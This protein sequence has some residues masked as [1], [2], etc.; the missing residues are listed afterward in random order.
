MFDHFLIFFFITSFLMIFIAK[1]FNLLVDFKL[2]KHKRFSTKSKSYFIG[3]TLLLFFFIYYFIF[4]EKNYLLIS[5][6]ISIFTIGL[7]SDLKILNSVKLR[8]LLQIFISIFFIYYL[9][10]KINFTRVDFFDEILQNYIVINIL[11]TTFC[12]LIVINGGNF[13]DGLNGLILKYNLII[14]LILY[15]SFSSEFFILDKQ[16]ASYL[17]IILSIILFLN[18]FGYLYM[19]DSGAYLLSLF[20]GLYLINFSSQNFALSPYFIILL[21]W[22]PCFELLFSM[23]R[24]IRKKLKTYKPDNFHLH[25]FIYKLI[26]KKLSIKNDLLSHFITSFLINIYNLII[27][28]ISVQFIYDSE[29]LILILS[30]NITLYLLIYNYS[31]KKYKLEFYN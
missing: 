9:N 15:F 23:I 22:Y 7:F 14:Y 17:I 11:F 27:F 8:F 24:R 6:L 4:L 30:I 28:I 2:E 29:I 31:Q 26:K 3:G 1:K 21:L 25:Q 19:G 18:L 20:T 16:I 13:I 12:L 10:L 5:F